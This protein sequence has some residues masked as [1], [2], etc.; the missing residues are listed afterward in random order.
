V[1]RG[2]KLIRAILALMLVV[3]AVRYLGIVPGF[4]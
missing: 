3:V 4:G 1:S 2:E